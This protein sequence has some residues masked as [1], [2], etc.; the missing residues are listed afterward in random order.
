MNLQTFLDQFGNSLSD[1]SLAGLLVA[2]GA[3]IVACAI[4]PCTLPVGIGIAGLVSTNTTEKLSTGFPVALSF[5]LGIVASL[6]IL[7]AIA[8]HIGAC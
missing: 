2:F 5:F 6:S 1:G 4:C 8:G 7:G 3:G